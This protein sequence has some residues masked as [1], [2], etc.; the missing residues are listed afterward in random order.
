MT[1]RS[2]LIFGSPLQVAVEHAGTAFYKIGADGQLSPC[3]RVPVVVAECGDFLRKNGNTPILSTGPHAYNY[4]ATEVEGIFRLNG[5]FKRMK[6]LQAIFEDSSEYG[7]G[8]DWAGFTVHDAAGI[9]RRYLNQLSEPVVPLN[10]YERFKG[11]MIKCN[12]E[13]K[14]PKQADIGDT[15]RQ[16]V[17]TYW[18]LVRALPSINQDLFI[19]ILDLL[20]KFCSKSDYTRMT[21]ENL[22]AAFQP[23]ILSHPAYENMNTKAARQ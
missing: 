16:F 15:T 23:A 17:S 2:S 19:Y 5:S 7:E 14:S 4:E 9:L 20:A 13:E 12:D 3:G 10:M 22:A 6:H 1:D 21:A 11:P 8:L 18:E